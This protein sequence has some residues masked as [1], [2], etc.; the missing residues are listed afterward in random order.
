PGAQGRLGLDRAEVHPHLL[1]RRQRF[2]AVAQARAHLGEGHVADHDPAAAQALAQ[3]GLDRVGAPAVDQQFHQ[4]GGLDRDHSLGL[5]GSASASSANLPRTREMASST[6]LLSTMRL[7]SSSTLSTL[8]LV[9]P[10]ASRTA[11]GRVIWPRSATVAS[12]AWILGRND[13]DR[14]YILCNAYLEP[15]TGSHPSRAG[16]VS[17]PPH[18]AA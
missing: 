15:H 16:V 1:Q 5:P 14:L 12:I 13:M 17:G 18:E 3:A 11:L 10:S 4:H 9:R 7:P 2:G 8:P 6:C